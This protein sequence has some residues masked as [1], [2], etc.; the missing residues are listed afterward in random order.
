MEKY[1]LAIDQGTSS[2][3]AMIYTQN[4]LAFGTVDSFLIWR[5]TQGT[6]HATDITNASRTLLFNIFNQTWDNELLSLKSNRAHLAR[7]A[8]ESV[9]YQTKQILQ[10]MQQDSNMAIKILRV[11]GGMPVNDWFLQFLS[12]Q[13]QLIVQKP[14]DIETTAQGAALLAALGCEEVSSIAALKEC[15][16]YE[17]EFLPE[18][19]QNQIESNFQGW[20]NA[21]N[22]LLNR[23]N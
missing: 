15:W 18:N 16:Q 11:D 9:C 22:M 19:K 10:C 12:S 8:L 17:K 1:L 21:V 20:L 6:V 2:T 5:F 14:K 4:R 3:R 23:N 13:C 7:A